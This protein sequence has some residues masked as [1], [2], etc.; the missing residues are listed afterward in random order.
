M[1][2]L[3]IDGAIISRIPGDEEIDMDLID[4]IVHNTRNT[5]QAGRREEEKR[6]D[7]IQ[8]K[9]AEL[10]FE[11][12]IAEHTG[13]RYLSYDD[14][15]SDGFQK[16]A[17]FDGL[18]IGRD[19]RRE[20]ERESI[21]AIN[22]EIAEGSEVGTISPDLRKKLEDKG[23]FTL[24]IKSSSLKNRDYEGV[25]NAVRRTREACGQIVRNLERWDFFV[26]PHYLRTSAEVKNFY[27]YTE[28]VRTYE[29]GFPQGNERFLRLLMIDEYEHASNLYTRFYFDYAK[30]HIYLPGYILKEDFFRNP[31]IMHMPG[32]KSGM[33]LYY[34]YGLRNRTPFSDIDRD[35]RIWAYDREAAYGRLFAGREHRC[36]ICGDRL[37]ICKSTGNRGFFYRCYTC[38]RNFSLESVIEEQ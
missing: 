38:E 3:E 31:R 22:R 14:F 29:E 18:L 9:K 21:H 19:T 1:K 37:R 7:T 25:D 30:E 10:V 32:I 24:E 12:Y 34:M 15:R 4:L 26:Y 27:D 6:R 13:H 36:G 17:P 8:G 35:Q 28:Y 23:I 2:F 33:A 16:H 5:W 20:V 11:R